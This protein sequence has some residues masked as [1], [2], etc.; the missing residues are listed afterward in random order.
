MKKL[1]LMFVLLLSFSTLA[2]PRVT[3]NGGGGI[4]KNGI[5]KTFYSSG[6]L[7]NPNEETDIPGMTLLTNTIVSVTS[8]EKIFPSYIPSS[9]RK[10]YNIIESDVN[11]ENIDRLLAEYKRAVKQPQENLAIFAI[12][13]IETKTTFLLPSFYQL[14]EIEQAAILFHEAYWIMKPSASYEEVI[15]AEVA[16]Q[17]FLEKDVQGFY[18][19]TFPRLLGDLTQDRTIPLK[20]SLNFDIKNNT[21]PAIINEDGVLVTALNPQSACK[22]KVNVL[23]SLEHRNFLPSKKTNYLNEVSLTCGYTYKSD[24]QPFYINLER[25]YPNSRLIKELKNAFLTHNSLMLY[26][27][28]HWITP[29]TTKKVADELKVNF[30]NLSES[31]IG[32]LYAPFNREMQKTRIKNFNVNDNWLTFKK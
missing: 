12:T 27:D 19:P 6:V 17:N 25:T 29:E 4:H 31:E 7:I 18:S 32:K 30:S 5:Y 23:Y 14:T 21:E 11:K 20:A 28:E 2:G 9:A 24:A 1:V 15:A 22:T 26:K 10:Y 16:F 3:G 13:E 8:N